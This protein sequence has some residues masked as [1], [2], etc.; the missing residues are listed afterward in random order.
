MRPSELLVASRP[1]SPADPRPVPLASLTQTPLDDWV[2]NEE[3]GARLL[4]DHF[5]VATLAGYGLEG[6][7]LAVAAAGAI[8]HYVRETQRGSLSH[9]D[10]I[11][12]YQQQDSL[13]LDP[14]TLRNL[15]L[16]EPAFGESRATTLLGVLDEC[17]TSLGAR[18]LKQW[19]L[20][21]S[22][23]RQSL[24]RAWTWSRSSGNPPSG[25]KNCGG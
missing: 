13:I 14:A 9:L 15:E 7:A 18:K 17:V 2:F 16:L 1:T 23:D 5:G 22:V 12:F 6:H 25:G 3:Y 11:R 21:P 20:H 10:G 8:L 24:K 4:R 19:I